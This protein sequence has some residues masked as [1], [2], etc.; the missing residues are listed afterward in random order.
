[1]NA[2][3]KE[4]EVV[5]TIRFGWAGR[6]DEVLRQLRTMGASDIRDTVT[7]N[8]RLTCNCPLGR[9]LHHGLIRLRK[10][11]EVDEVETPGYWLG[12]AV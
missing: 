12:E 6:H 5:I 3:A 8:L 2:G 7:S 1:M 9:R 11:E 4:T 10:L